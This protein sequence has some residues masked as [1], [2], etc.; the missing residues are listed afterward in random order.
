VQQF[1]EGEA[2]TYNRHELVKMPDQ[3]LAKQSANGICNHAS[4][5]LR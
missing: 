2:C 5:T 4:A 3:V 1:D